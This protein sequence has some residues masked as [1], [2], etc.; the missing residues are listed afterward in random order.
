MDEKHDRGQSPM[1]AMNRERFSPLP[2]FPTLHQGRLII[3]LS[4]MLADGKHAL[5]G[6]VTTI[7]ILPSLLR[8]QLRPTKK[9]LGDISVNL[10]LFFP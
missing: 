6:S 7:A 8:K 3:Y 5:R 9:H 1:C 10:K 2:E 4:Q